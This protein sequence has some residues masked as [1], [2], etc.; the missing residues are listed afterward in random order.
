MDGGLIIDFGEETKL[1][2]ITDKLNKVGK[3]LL[4]YINGIQYKKITYRIIDYYV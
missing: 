3:N 4:F 1:N 2:E